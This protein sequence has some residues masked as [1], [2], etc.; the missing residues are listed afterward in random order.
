MCNEL[1]TRREV[2]KTPALV[3]SLGV[4]AADDSGFRHRAYLGWITDLDSRPDTNAPWPSMR[5]DAALLEDYRR[6]FALMKRLGYNVIVIWGFY[7]S[8]NW[9]LDIASAVTPER[10]AL[11]GRLIDQAHEQGIRVYTGLGVYS[12]GFQEIIRANPHLSRGN[13]NALCASRPESW[14]W[15]RKV[16]DFAMTRFPVDGVSLQSADQGR[17]PCQECRRW[18]DTEYHAHLDIRVSEYI[19]A[20]WAGKTVA[21]SGWGMRFDDPKSLPAL[22]ELSRRIDYLIDVRDSTRQHDAS[23]RKSL[24]QELACS[25]GTLGG[26]QVEPPQ[27]LARDR[28][29]LPVVRRSGEHLSDLYRDGGRACEYFFHI[30]NNPGDEISFWVAGKTLRDPHTDW[31]KHLAA[32]V[33]ELYVTTNRSAVEALCDIFVRAEDAYLRHVPALRSG[34]ISIEPLDEDHAGPPIYI[35]K[36]LTSEQRGQYRD[37][38]ATIATDLQKL[39]RAV[40]EKVR[41]QKISGCLK[42]VIA[43]LSSPA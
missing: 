12:W 38:L 4:A 3:L 33:E 29:F 43:D 18:S 6:T 39:S 8:R 37:E 20:H 32:S 14:E 21:V 30:L 25:F 26:P 10:G 23:W 16:I 2:L 15:M 11:V 42:N 31:H 24:I 28:W 17:C 7:V 1:I 40:P 5:L 19:R 34:T 41:L 27:H 13:P 22:V 35:T 9:P 36:R